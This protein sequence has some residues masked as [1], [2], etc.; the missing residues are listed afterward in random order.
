MT[1]ILEI[2][3]APAPSMEVWSEPGMTDE[4]RKACFRN[5]SLQRMMDR[6]AKDKMR[7]ILTSSKRHDFTEQDLS[8]MS[9]D[10]MAN[11]LFDDWSQYYSWLAD[12]V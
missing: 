4:A 9:R 3:D 10:E 6:L 5:E 8:K 2:L 1:R 7:E 11:L 12:P